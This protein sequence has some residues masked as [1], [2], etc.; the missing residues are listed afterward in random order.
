[1]AFLDADDVW[2]PDKLKLQ[3]STMTSSKAVISGHQ[4]QYKLDQHFWQDQSVEFMDVSH[5]SIW[6]MMLS[7]RLSTPTVM[8]KRS[9]FIPFDE[10]LQRAEDW[11]CWVQIMAANKL[12]IVFIPHVLASGSKPSLGY[13]GL[14]ADVVSMHKYLMLA[15][16]YLYSEN[17]ITLLQYLSACIAEYVKYPIRLIRIYLIKNL[18]RQRF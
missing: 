3:M 16:K 14:S 7:N 6:G 18:I 9:F 4:Y 5:I 13:S 17:K 15:I 12:P 11:K 1:L 2:H 10:R 8:I